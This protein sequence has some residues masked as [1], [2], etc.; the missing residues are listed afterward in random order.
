M[1]SKK[2]QRNNCFHQRQITK[3][4][5]Y[6][7]LRIITH[8]ATQ[9]ERLRQCS[10][11]LTD[12]IQMGRIIANGYTIFSQTAAVSDSRTAKTCKKTSI[13]KMRGKQPPQSRPIK[14]SAISSDVK[15][16]YK[17]LIRERET[18][19]NKRKR[20][21]TSSANIVYRTLYLI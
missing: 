12:E 10:V 16:L 17:W 9:K 6:R 13:Q 2:Y 3:N 1:Y 4:F 11:K 19:K 5:K 21:S 8:N 7:S 20:R 18:S 15:K 14:R